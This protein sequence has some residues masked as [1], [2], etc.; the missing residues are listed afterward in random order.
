MSDNL[1]LQMRSVLRRTSSSIGLTLGRIKFYLELLFHIDVK[2]R[3]KEIKQCLV[4]EMSSGRVQKVKNKYVLVVKSEPPPR[5]GLAR[6]SERIEARKDDRAKGSG[7]RSAVPGSSGAGESRS[8]L[9]PR[10]T[11]EDRAIRKN[12]V[13]TFPVPRSPV[14]SRGKKLAAN[15]QQ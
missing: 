11:T 4:A 8:E 12:P 5:S 6:K 13:E 10:Q 2:A 3:H 1:G 7:R 15:L 9:R 14:A